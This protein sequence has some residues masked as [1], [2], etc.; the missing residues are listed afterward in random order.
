MRSMRIWLE[1]RKKTGEI[2]DEEYFKGRD[3]KQEQSG[4]LI[5][6]FQSLKT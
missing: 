6:D 2:D 5:S 1:L 3:V 4:A